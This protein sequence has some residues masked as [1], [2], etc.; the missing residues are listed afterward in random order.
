MT[1]DCSRV[2]GA[3]IMKPPPL[4]NEVDHCTDAHCD[5]PTCI[6]YG[7]NFHKLSATDASVDW[8]GPYDVLS[9][10]QYGAYLFGRPETG[11]LP[12][13]TATSPK[14]P[15]RDGNGVVPTLLDLQR[16]CNLY[17][18]D[19]RGICGD[20]ILS[21]NNGEECDDGNN[22]DGDGCD[23]DCRIRT[24]P[25]V[26]GNG[27]LE[28][29]E[30]CDD[31]NTVDGDGCNAVCKTEYCGDGIV[32]PGLGEECD[33][34]PAGSSDCTSTCKKACLQTCDPDPRENKCD[35]TTSCISIEGGSGSG[36]HYCACAHGFRGAGVAAGDVAAQMRLPWPSQQGRVFVRPGVQCNVLCDQWTLGRD[37]CTEVEER[38]MCYI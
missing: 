1:L 16:V 27:I 6:D 29:G 38:A 19:C 12:P 8:S 5:P 13:M 30:E 34:G 33:D 26:C 18:K 17:Y 35:Q 32:Q 20:G 2:C 36:T 24:P 4:Q 15:L 22:D 14:I 21:P 25:P 28:T 37:G 7:C 11:Y 9:I 23:S 31:G 10:M 3:Y